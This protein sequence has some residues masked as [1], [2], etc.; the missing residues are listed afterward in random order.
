MIRKT[1]RANSHAVQCVENVIVMEHRWGSFSS[2]S[3]SHDT[4]NATSLLDGSKKFDLI[5]GSD[6][7]YR[8]YLYD[9]LIRSIQQF[10]HS[11]TI[12]LVGVTMSDTTPEFFHRLDRAGFIWQKFADS[13]L[14]PEFRGT[15]FGIFAIQQQRKR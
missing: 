8:E 4:A 9:P 5:I 2:N 15:T 12:S 3:D 1:I 10:S 6:V 14:A 13:L 7:A 11:Q